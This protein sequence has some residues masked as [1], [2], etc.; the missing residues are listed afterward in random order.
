MN[1]A[2]FKL[3][4]TGHNHRNKQ[5]PEINDWGDE[6]VGMKTTRKTLISIFVY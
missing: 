6:G 3:R 2:F 1:V 4:M 5:P